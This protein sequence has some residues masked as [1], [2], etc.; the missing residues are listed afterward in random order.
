MI[1]FF[2]TIPISST[3]PMMEM[4]FRSDFE[5]HQRQHCADAGRRQ[6]GDDRQWMHQALVQD[7]E[8]DIDRQQ[9]RDDQ[10]RA[11]CSAIVGRP[12]VPAKKP[13]SWKASRALLHLVDAPVASLKRHIRREIE[14]HRDRR[15]QARMVDGQ[16]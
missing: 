9:R 5:E 4:T 15:E 11:R 10:V 3:M 8:H 1:A 13:A 6:G 7:A 14:R 12:E 16:R 2:F